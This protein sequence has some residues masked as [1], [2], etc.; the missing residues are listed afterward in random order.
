MAEKPEIKVTR[1]YSLSPAVIEW[2]A[3]KAKRIVVESNGEERH[4]ESKIVNDLLTAAMEEAERNEAQ[5]KDSSVAFAK[6][7]VTSK[8]RT[9]DSI[10]A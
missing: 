6:R 10:P 4:N 8:Y 5:K 2:V 1:T 3:E 7:N 9:K